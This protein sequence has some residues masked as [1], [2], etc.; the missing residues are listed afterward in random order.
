MYQ[1]PSEILQVFGTGIGVEI[2]I[3]AS[4]DVAVMYIVVPRYGIT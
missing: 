2:V 4:Y 3:F 1:C